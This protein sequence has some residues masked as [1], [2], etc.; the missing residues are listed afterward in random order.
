MFELSRLMCHASVAITDKIY[1]H[2]RK[3]DYAAQRARF[4]AF[5]NLAEEVSKDAVAG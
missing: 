4:S 2:L 1:A 3:K 5:R